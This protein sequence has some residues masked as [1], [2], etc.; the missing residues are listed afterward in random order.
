MLGGPHF[1]VFEMWDPARA[2]NFADS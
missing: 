1:A 2:T